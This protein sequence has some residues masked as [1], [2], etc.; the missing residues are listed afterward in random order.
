MD[1]KEGKLPT[2]QFKGKSFVQ[3]HHLSVPYHQLVPN[4]SQ[5]LTGEIS[6]QDN[7]IIHGD[8]LLA[9]K[10]LL[11]TYAGKI[12]CIYIDPPYNTGN[13]G[14]VYNDKVNSPFINEWIG[15]VVG[16]EGEDFTRHDKWLC[17]M[18]PRLKLL[19]EL[20]ADDGVIFIS[21]DDNEQHNLRQLADEIF[22][23]QNFVANIIWQKKQSPQNDA[24][25]FSD[26]HDF[27]VVYAKIKSENGGFL[28]NKLVRNETHNA[29]FKNPDNDERGIWASGDLSSNKT[30]E[31]RPNLYYSITNPQ[32]KEIWPSE[33]RVW[34]YE[35]S[36]M[37]RLLEEERISWGNG[38]SF[39][40]LKLFLSEIT[41]GVVPST[42]WTRDFAGDNQSSRREYR[43]IFTSEETDFATPKPVSL[44]EKILK[45]GS[46]ED[47]LILDSFAGSGTTA[48]AVL[49][50]NK[51]DGGNRKFIPVEMEDYAETITAER[52][53]R[54]IKGIPN[55]RNE[56]LKEGLGGTFS[57]FDLGAPI[58]VSSILS[59]ESM[60][61]YLELAR[62]LYYTSTGE[63]FNE[64][65][66]DEPRG[67]IGTSSQ[68]DIYMFYKPDIVYLKQTALTLDLAR[69]LRETAGQ[70]SLLVFAPT[71]YVETSELDNLRITFCQL[72]FELYKVNH[73]AS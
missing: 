1:P 49:E 60:P 53:R 2:I 71:K 37:E 22:G 34:R 36:T 44:I 13:E 28:I 5:S 55:S 15:K 27:I 65:N 57:Y 21:I 62:Y 6:L 39:P 26:M 35:R 25:Y 45:I 56:N 24:H 73:G 61:S 4:Q 30:K 42:L 11:P 52:V 31:E 10:A 33:K 18:M 40:R 8:N 32:G 69:E 20:L 12:K 59:G 7:L 46:N 16:K 66:I 68:Y 38:E 51:E 47:S 70:R 14:W 43:S 19:R 64:S 54:V 3:N 58:E 29:R 23:D 67:F 17:M 48:Q 72:P 50:L 9:L 63:E 41:T